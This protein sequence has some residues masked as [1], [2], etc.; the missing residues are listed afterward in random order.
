MLN[1]FRQLIFGHSP[2]EPQE[3]LRMTPERLQAAL[4]AAN[5]QARLEDASRR[6]EMKAT[7][8]ERNRIIVTLAQA[9]DFM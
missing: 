8:L 2:I 1:H 6:Q 4:D 7:R 5:A 9:G 3:R